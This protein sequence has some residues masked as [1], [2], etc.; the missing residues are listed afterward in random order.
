MSNRREFLAAGAASVAAATLPSAVHA[1]GSDVIKVGLIGCGGRGT[2]AANDCLTA[3]KEGVKLVAVGDVFPSK[4][5]SAAKTLANKYKDRVDLGDRVYGGLDAYEKVINAGVD[6]VLLATPPGFRPMH[7][8]A[9]VKA[10]KHIFCEK[11]VAVDAPGIRKCL[12]LVEDVKTKKLALVAGTQ[13]RHQAGYLET[14]KRVHGGEIGEIVSGRCSWNGQGIWFKKREAGESDVAYQLKNWYHFMWVCGDHIVEQ[15][16]HNLDV[17][18]WA[19]GAHP[20]RAVGFGGRTPGNKSRPSGDANDV[21]HI[22]DHFAVEFEY[23]NGVHVSSYCTHVENVSTDISE[24]LYGSKG[25]CRVNAYS[26]NKKKVFENDPVSAYVQEHI[27][28][29]ASIKSGTPL[30]ELQAVTESTF[31]AI[32]GRDAAYSGQNLKWDDLLRSERVA[33]PAG[34]TMDSKVSVTGTPV[35]G[36]YDL[37]IPKKDDKK[38]G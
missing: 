2:G 22:W 36:K 5:Q 7:L 14:M 33:M 13:R 26:I 35:P 1:A 25:T 15:H 38:R 10:G 6:L 30:N 29:L 19:L 24:T 11:P 4:A 21:G 18:N 9:A 17:M 27:D 12:S 23:P 20:I 31:T 37:M 16:I 28:L 32:L 8:E 34:L 3:G